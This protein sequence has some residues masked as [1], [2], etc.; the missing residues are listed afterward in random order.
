MPNAPDEVEAFKTVVAR[1]RS[2][3]SWGRQ[4]PEPETVLAAG[5]LGA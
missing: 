1:G 5:E 2:G 3:P 4:F